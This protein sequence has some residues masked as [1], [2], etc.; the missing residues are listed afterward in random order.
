LTA[1]YAAVVVDDSVCLKRRA[2]S[3]DH[4]RRR[5]RV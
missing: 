2:G 5:G 3:F 1:R 4:R